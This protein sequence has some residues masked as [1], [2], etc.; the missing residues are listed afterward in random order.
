MSIG[1]PHVSPKDKPL[2]RK[3]AMG[4]R[5]ALGILWCLDTR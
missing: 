5:I 1:P 4:Y 3:V 2:R